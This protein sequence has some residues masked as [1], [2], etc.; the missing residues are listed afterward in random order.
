MRPNEPTLK[1]G[2]A[3]WSL[4][5]LKH[6]RLAPLLF[7][8]VVLFATVA[9]AQQPNEVVQN[10]ITLRGTVEAVDTK[11]RTVRIRGDRGN[12]VTIDIPMSGAGLDQ[13]QAGD[14][15]TV[16]YFDRV[17][18]RPKPAGEA[19]VDRTDPP[20]ATATPGVLPEATIASQRV[21]TVTIT[22]WDPAL[23]T[24]TFTGP[25]GTVYTRRLIDGTD[26]KIM[27]GLKIGD[28]VDV[29]RT[30]AVRLQVEQ[31]TQSVSTPRQ[32]FGIA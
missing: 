25:G 18:V 8:S 5:V 17:S 22:G 15:V 29:T 12:V 26:A 24:V 16:A 32:P 19:S 1:I 30:E 11:A 4:A 28:R 9:R 31:R 10:Q 3:I 2:G 7:L 13:L 6:I 23:R 20:V 14:I 21:T 27:A